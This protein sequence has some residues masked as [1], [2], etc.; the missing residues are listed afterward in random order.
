MKNQERYENTPHFDLIVKNGSITIP[1]IFMFGKDTGGLFLFVSACRELNCTLRFENEDL[2]FDPKEFDSVA[3]MK[4]T[5]Y[6]GIMARPQFVENYIKYL[7]HKDEM[8]WDKV[9]KEVE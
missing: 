8:S 6:M 9:K 7:F 1:S 3:N 5:T 4:L 2:T